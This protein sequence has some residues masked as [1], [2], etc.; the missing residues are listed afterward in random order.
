[1]SLHCFRYPSLIERKEAK[2]LCVFSAEQLGFHGYFF[3][4]LLSG[5]AIG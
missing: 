2:F 1:M 4:Y 3:G 5:F